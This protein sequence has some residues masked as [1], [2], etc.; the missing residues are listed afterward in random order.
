MG[1][2]ELDPAEVRTGHRDSKDLLHICA[3]C[4]RV[5]RS[6]GAWER[7]QDLEKR[8]P[9]ATHGI[10]PGCFDAVSSSF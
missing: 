4:L 8:L 10:C 7:V 5:R 9:N 1:N 2:A 3:W 6:D